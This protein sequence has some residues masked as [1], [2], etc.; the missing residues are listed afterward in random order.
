MKL[1]RST[2]NTP[3]RNRRPV[4]ALGVAAVAV[5][6]L[7]AAG[8]APVQAAAPVAGTAARVGLPASTV[9]ASFRKIPGLPVAPTAWAG[10]QD[11]EGNLVVGAAA[12]TTNTRDTPMH[13]FVYDLAHP[14]TPPRDLGTF[15]GQSVVGDSQATAIDNG[16]VVGTSSG[17]GS[18]SEHAFA[19]DTTAPAPVLRDLGHLGSG[20]GPSEATDIDGNVVV[21][22]STDAKGTRPFAYD[23]AA[24]SPVMRDLGSLGGRDARATRIVGNLVIGWS[25]TATGDQHPF[26]YDLAAANPVMRDLGS[27]G[28]KNGWASNVHGT[29]I[30]GSAQ[31]A[32]GLYHAFVYDLAAANPVMRDLGVLPG[33]DESYAGPLVGDTLYGGSGNAFALDVADPSARMRDLGSLGGPDMPGSGTRLQVA[34]GDFVYGYS[35]RAGDGAT[36]AVVYDRTAADPELVDLPGGT[37][38]V[39]AADGNVAVG[40]GGVWTLSRTTAPSIRFAATTT[41]VQESVGRASITVV[42]AGDASQAVSARYT[43][44]SIAGTPANRV[45]HESAATAGKDYRSTSGTIRFAAGQT[46]AQFTV[47]I[48]NDGSPE[49]AD[50]FMVALSAAQIASGPDAGTALAIGT[51]NTASVVIATSDQRPDALVSRR[52]S[53]KGFLGNNVYNLTGKKQTVTVDARRGRARSV[54]VKVAN[55]GNALTTLTFR[56]GAAPA[57]TSVRYFSGRVDVTRQVRSTAG[58]RL[59]TAPHASHVLRVQ[60]TPS[61][62]AAAGSR[63]VVSVSGNWRGDGTRRDVVRAAVRIRR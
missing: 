63:K 21:G 19:Y 18:A 35:T 62:G 48:I 61:K 1:D 24:A 25:T 54:W 14:D 22:D 42:R 53:S 23:L 40:G 27:L 6:V 3:T 57:R 29:R 43:T 9:T 33:A 2:P 50:T 47:P 38:R 30:V 17:T 32:D 13:A 36:R 56:A 58:F 4:A 31:N 39:S 12:T 46:R 59:R 51:P 55:D 11:V 41:R 49:V 5:G 16:V 45:G 37:L 26:V 60:V 28:G 8:L 44:R 20:L 15:G 52:S 10:P 34:S 7:G